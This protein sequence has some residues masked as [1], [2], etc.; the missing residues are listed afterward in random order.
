[1]KNFKNLALS[2]AVVAALFVST[3]A[4][5]EAYFP[6]VK[7]SVKAGSVAAA[8]DQAKT[9][10]LA[11]GFE[12]VGEYAPNENTQIM[13]VTNNTLK[14]LAASSENGG[15]GAME[16]V[17]IVSRGGEVDVSYTNPTYQYNVY[18]MKGDI[19]GV[20]AAMEKALGNVGAFGAEEGL[21]AKELREYH[22]KIMMPYFD[23]EDEL[24]SYSSYEEALR[25]VEAG[26]AAKK[27]GVSKVYRID[28][29]GVKMSVIGVALSQGE[30]ADANILAQIDKSGY[31]HAAHLPYEILIVNDQA[32]ALNGKFRI[33]INWP[34]LSM[35]GTG[36]F[37]SIANAPD[38][39]KAALEAVAE[40]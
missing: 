33:A 34:S 3:Q 25:T 1:M 7:G 29:P 17:A 28:I 31:S 30:G 20:Q 35:M 36:S 18:R 22:Y 21:S 10:L 24:A 27:M 4:L 23:D 2:G 12:V 13:V 37:M 14:N 38:D 11:N 19:S 32:I 6:F 26:L 39:I 40:K 16:R 9:R 8:V 15:F 5:A